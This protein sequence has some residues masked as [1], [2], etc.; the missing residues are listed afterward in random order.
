M[1]RSSKIVLTYLAY[2]ALEAI[3]FAI[4]IYQ[5]NHL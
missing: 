1:R 2:L 3:G 5:L 4:V